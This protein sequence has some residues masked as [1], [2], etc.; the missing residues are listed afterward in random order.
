MNCEKAVFC[1]NNGA[2]F[3]KNVKIE[4]TN[5]SIKNTKLIQVLDIFQQKIWT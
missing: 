4:P 5:H 2:I 1:K 3:L